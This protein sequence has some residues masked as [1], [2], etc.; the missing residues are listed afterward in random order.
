MQD[1]NG[2]LIQDDLANLRKV[3]SV[4]YSIAS[5]PA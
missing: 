3:Y 5:Q 1:H 2:E 4:H